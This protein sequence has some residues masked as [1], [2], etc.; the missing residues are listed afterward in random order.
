MR[1]QEIVNFCKHVWR[2]VVCVSIN[3]Y[4]QTPMVSVF[5]I[6]VFFLEAEMCQELLQTL[7][8]K[9]HLSFC[10]LVLLFGFLCYGLICWWC[11]RE[12]SCTVIHVKKENKLYMLLSFFFTEL[13]TLPL[14]FEMVWYCLKIFWQVVCFLKWSALRLCRKS[15]GIFAFRVSAS[16]MISAE[17]F[18][19]GFSSVAVFDFKHIQFLVKKSNEK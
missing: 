17:S 6:F 4:L 11:L 12:L 16:R 2:W 15:C 14:I 18:G 3:P 1:A 13:L 8:S 10:I 19:N 9:F 5:S 7:L